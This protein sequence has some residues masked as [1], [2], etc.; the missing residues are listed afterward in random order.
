M[1]EKPSSSITLTAQV[2]NVKGISKTKISRTLVV[3]EADTSGGDNTGGD[4]GDDGDG[5]SGIDDGSGD[6]GGDDGN[7]YTAA[8]LR[9]A[10]A[11]KE[12]EISEAKQDLHEAQ[13]NY[14]EAKAEVGKATVKAK[15]AGTVTTSCD[16]G[17]VSYR[18]FGGYRS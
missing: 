1:K 13:I 12:D 18:W 4:G 2:K 10:I 3:K 16:K 5:G 7:N 9:E 8:E 11:E 17:T 6:N 14:N 15:I